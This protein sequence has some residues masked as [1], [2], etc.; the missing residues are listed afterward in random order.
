MKPWR[1]GGRKILCFLAT[2]CL[3]I[4]GM[5]QESWSARPLL[6]RFLESPPPGNVRA[7][8]RSPSETSRGDA[9]N[10]L[11]FFMTIRPPLLHVYSLFSPPAQRKYAP[12]LFCHVATLYGE[13]RPACVL[14][15]T[16]PGYISQSVHVYSHSTSVA[17]VREGSLS[18][19]DGC[20]RECVKERRSRGMFCHKKY[21]FI[22][23][24]E[25]V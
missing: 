23:D 9:K 15:C 1:P 24:S 11:K 12:N 7:K 8:I 14:C 19:C 6:K 20:V 25:T 2:G 13:Y 17:V 18:L 10:I 16:Q 4:Q 22:T 21:F 3:A 5:F